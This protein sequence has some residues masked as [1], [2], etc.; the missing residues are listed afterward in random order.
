MVALLTNISQGH[1]GTKRMVKPKVSRMGETQQQENSGNP[2]AK[3]KV[4]RDC[5]TLEAALTKVVMGSLEISLCTRGR[6]TS[7][8]SYCSLYF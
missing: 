7:T 8:G 6:Q 3:G 4:V 1:N 2:K 5:Q